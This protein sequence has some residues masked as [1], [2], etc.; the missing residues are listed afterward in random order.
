[1]NK[2]HG[3]WDLFVDPSLGAWTQTEWNQRSEDEYEDDICP[4]T[5]PHSGPRRRLCPSPKTGPSCSSRSPSGDGE[6]SHLDSQTPNAS[7]R[8]L[9]LAL[10]SIHVCPIFLPLLFLRFYRPEGSEE[11]L[12]LCEQGLEA[13]KSIASLVLVR[14]AGQD[15]PWARTGSRKWR[16]A[17]INT[18]VSSGMYPS[19]CHSILE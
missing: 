4:S 18:I 6:F 16:S 5:P 15:S 13:P 8:I 3:L 1:M 2:K 11:A 17:T 12:I 7:T 14:I 19:L 9:S 10:N